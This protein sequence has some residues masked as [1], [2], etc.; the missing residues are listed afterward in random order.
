MPNIW[1]ICRTKHK[2]GALWD[3]PNLKNYTT[4]LQYRCKFATVRTNVAKIILFYILFS[5]SSLFIFSFL[6]SLTLRFPLPS[7]CAG[8]LPL[9]PVRDV[10]RQRRRR[11]SN[12]DGVAPTTTVRS[13]TLDLAPATHSHPRSSHSISLTLSHAWSRRS[14]P[15]TTIDLTL[16][17]GPVTLPLSGCGFFFFFFHCNLGWSDGGGGLWVVGGDSG[18]GG[19]LWGWWPSPL[20]LNRWLFVCLNWCWIGDWYL[21]VFFFFFPVLLVVSALLGVWWWGGGSCCYLAGHVWWWSGGWCLSL[22]G[23]WYLFVIGGWD[24][25]LF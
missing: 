11:S 4:W 24:N 3:V 15:E 7:P 23:D 9:R 21:L 2:N 13:A 19:G 17:H 20:C 22:L 8:S 1:H 25:I 6:F 12:D 18:S 14:H 5:L 16:S 10:H